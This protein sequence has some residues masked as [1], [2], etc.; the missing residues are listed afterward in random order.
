MADVTFFLRFEVIL[1]VLQFRQRQ[2]RRVRN[3]PMP[4]KRKEAEHHYMLHR[5]KWESVGNDRFPGRLLARRFAH[6]RPIPLIIPRS[7]HV[8][9]SLL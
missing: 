7:H 2:V 5:Y 9:V 4:G 3:P 8:Y 6:C 1:A